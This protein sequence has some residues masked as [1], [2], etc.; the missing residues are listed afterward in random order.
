MEISYPLRY[1]NVG[2][3]FSSI[4]KTETGK[5]LDS[6]ERIRQSAQCWM[7]ESTQRTGV[8]VKERRRDPENTGSTGL[9][10]VQ[11]DSLKGQWN[12]D[13]PTILAHSAHLPAY[14]CGAVMGS[15]LEM[16]LSELAALGVK[17]PCIC[18]T[19]GTQ[20]KYLYTEPVI[21][22]LR[23]TLAPDESLKLNFWE[24]CVAG[25]YSVTSKRTEV[26]FPL[27]LA[28]WKVSCGS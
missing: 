5:T 13:P 23:V 6:E 14:T 27:G 4:L 15:H 3:Y 1:V 10:M 20:S 7:Y 16:V 17:G 24:S 25:N 9:S 28:T 11:K 18:L 21:S 22:D 8:E 26:T 2:K 12:W 19:L